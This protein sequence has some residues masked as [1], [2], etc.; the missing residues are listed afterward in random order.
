METQTGQREKIIIRTS[1][2]GILTNV[3][4]AGFK[5]L[6]GFL[7]SSIAVVLDAVNNLSDAL[8]SIVT[9]IGTRLSAKP[10]DREHP[11]GHGRG[12]YLTAM[13]VAVLV[14]Y[15]GVTSLIESVKAIIH[16]ETPEYT[17][18]ALIVIAVAVAVKLL[19]GR[20]VQRTGE[21]VHSDSLVGSGRDALNDAIISA[22]TL[23]AA[24]IFLLWGVSLEAWLGLIIAGV[25]IKS[26]IDMLRETISEVL[27][28]RADADIA[29][30]VK[31][32]VTGVDGVMGAYDL[33]LHNYGPERLLGSVHVEIPDTM[34]AEAID[35][36]ERTISQRVYEETG[37][38]MTAVGIY[39]ANTTGGSAAQMRTE[40]TRMVMAHPHVLQLHG[41]YQDEEKKSVQFDTVIGFDAPDRV[42]L[43]KEIQQEVQAAYPDYTVT[44]TLD[45]D[46]AD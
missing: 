20:F 11:M 16:P 41:F 1:I 31:S 28:A 7:S 3:L 15:A 25:I 14:L 8:S 26:G 33:I 34:T 45:S 46:F 44:V 9:I 38:V 27:G 42:A 19:L 40:I 36:M 10:A 23:V 35:T 29:A 22:S 4:L 30:R 18:V 5:A 43:W 13:I 32:V 17:P 12:E 21:K 6:V 24:A 2:I 39:S 37:V